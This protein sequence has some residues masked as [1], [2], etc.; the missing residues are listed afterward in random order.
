MSFG[1]TLID[2]T[3][4]QPQVANPHQAL[5]D[6]IAFHC[7]I[8]YNFVAAIKKTIDACGLEAATQIVKQGVEQA[9]NS[10]QT[11]RGGNICKALHRAAFDGHEG[12]VRLLLTFPNAYALALMEDFPDGFTGFHWAANNGRRGVVSL[13]LDSPIASELL[14]KKST[15]NATVL[16]YVVYNNHIEVM[17]LFLALPNAR[18]LVMAQTND[19]KTA[20]HDATRYGKKSM[21]ELLLS[22]PYAQ[23]LADVKDVNGYTAYDFAVEPEIKA[24]L[25]PYQ[26]DICV[27]VANKCLESLVYLFTE[28]FK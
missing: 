10:I 25:R 18:E 14:A 27:W 13:Y 6:D 11:E 28:P 7:N 2:G 20:L 12:V 4:V 16:H 3:T 15:A 17:R 9:G 26:R 8:T 22:S 1:I 24:L 5:V 21:V 19:G 23:E